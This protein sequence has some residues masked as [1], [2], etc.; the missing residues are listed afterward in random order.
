MVFV[1]FWRTSFSIHSIF[2]D[3][4]AAGINQSPDS[5]DLIKQTKKP[6][7]EDQASRR[8]KGDRDWV[9]MSRELH[10]T[11]KPGRI[12][13]GVSPQGG[14]LGARDATNDQLTSSASSQPGQRK[15]GG[16]THKAPSSLAELIHDCSCYIMVIMVKT[17]F[18]K[19]FSDPVL[20][21]LLVQG[22]AFP[23]VIY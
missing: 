9:A 10:E 1:S 11:Q 18:P 2:I 15:M 5:Q 12:W 13:W 19:D 22:F 21:Q 3:S 16:E 4:N 20:L 8:S 14:N 7:E 17:G 6:T 23:L